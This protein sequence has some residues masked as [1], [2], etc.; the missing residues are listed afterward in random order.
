[1]TDEVQF[2][3]Y[4]PPEPPQGIPVADRKQHGP[5]VKMMNKMLPKRIKPRLMGKAKGV[6][7]DQNVHVKH[8]KVR[9]Y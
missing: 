9:F 8:K 7:A 4:Q 1:M 6:Q 2:P 3:N 5:L